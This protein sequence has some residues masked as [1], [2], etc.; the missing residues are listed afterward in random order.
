MSEGLAKGK[1]HLIVTIMLLSAFVTMLNQTILNTAMPAMIA[2]L[3]IPE[4]TGQW[5][6]TGFMI[7]SG[8]MIPLTAFFN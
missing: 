3:G 1:R 4:T 2:D 8:I 6:I 7:V 5:L